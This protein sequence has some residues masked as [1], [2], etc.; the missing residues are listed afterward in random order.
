M[1]KKKLTLYVLFGV[2][3]LLILYIACY[4]Y[5]IAIGF[6]EAVVNTGESYRKLRK[7]WNKKNINPIDSVQSIMKHKIDSL[8]LNK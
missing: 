6:G 5:W 4:Y 3:A 7:E 1:N 2:T 8:E